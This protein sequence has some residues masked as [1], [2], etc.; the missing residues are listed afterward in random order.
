[1]TDLHDLHDQATGTSDRLTAFDEGEPPGESARSVAFDRSEGW[2]TLQ[3]RVGNVAAELVVR[4]KSLG[5]RWLRSTAR[6]LVKRLLAPELDDVAR[7]RLEPEVPR[8][9]DLL[10]DVAASDLPAPETRM[11][12]DGGL[13]LIWKRQGHRLEVRLDPD[14]TPMVYLDEPGTAATLRPLG[15]GEGSVDL[16]RLLEGFRPARAATFIMGLADP[17]VGEPL[18][19]Q[20]TALRGRTLLHLV[21]SS[22][23]HL[24]TP[25][26][27]PG[28]DGVLG[29]TWETDAHHVS[30][31]VFP[32]GHLEVFH[33]DLGTGALWGAESRRDLPTEFVAR[34]NQAITG[35]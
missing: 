26:V 34:L 6:D 9:L 16:A 10:A 4:S 1:M 33:E 19:S 8:A 13:D 27:G 22:L 7:E 18:I 15:G 28:P 17:T 12:A 14:A 20:E 29:M 24:F 32:D 30:L 5:T 35:A 3:V 2:T 21:S 25:V 11:T 23:P 31:E